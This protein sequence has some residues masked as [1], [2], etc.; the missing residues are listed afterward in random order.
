[1][2]KPELRGLVLKK[3]EVSHSGVVHYTFRID[4]AAA[5][6]AAVKPDFP[7]NT[8]NGRNTFP[9][10][11]EG[12][13]VEAL[14]SLRRRSPFLYLLTNDSEENNIRTDS[15]IDVR[16]GVLDSR[17]ASH[18]QNSA[19]HVDYN[20]SGDF[21]RGSGIFSR[22]FAL[23][24]GDVTYVWTGI[25]NQLPSPLSY[26]MLLASVDVPLPTLGSMMER[27]ESRGEFESAILS[28]VELIVYVSE[29]P[30]LHVLTKNPELVL[31]FG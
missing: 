12:V 23:G 14:G 22:L 6:L 26:V 31:R 4:P 21:L 7:G 17:F 5:L 24:F 29:L 20:R 10:A 18:F 1:M 28:M 3:K 15:H 25:L 19:V 9:F 11:H 30:W 27:S 8:I 13:L 16:G 2:N